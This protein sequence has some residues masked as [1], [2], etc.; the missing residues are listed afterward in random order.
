MTGPRSKTGSGAL[1][2]QDHA[3]RA[4][5]MRRRGLTYDAIGRALGMTRQSAHALVQGAMKA[6]AAELKEEAT[7]VV[8]LDLARLDELHRV[9]WKAAKGGDLAAMDRVLKVMERRAKL[10]GLDA[11]TRSE[12]TGANGGPL[13]IEDVRARLIARIAAL[14]APAAAGPG[15]GG[16]ADN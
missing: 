6:A 9:A 3:A 2:S 11:P 5:T 13:A 4:V 8:A 12:V 15:A 10:L 16:D 14:A 7:E 1:K